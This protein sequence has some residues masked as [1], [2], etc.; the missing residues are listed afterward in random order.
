MIGL[1][2]A[3]FAVIVFLIM[4]GLLRVPWPI[5]VMAGLAGAAIGSFATASTW[6]ANGLAGLAPLVNAIGGAFG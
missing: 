4:W 5:L 6:I 3:G 2:A 1:S